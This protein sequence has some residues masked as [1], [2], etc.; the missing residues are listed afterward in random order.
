M[1]RESSP[2]A[3]QSVYCRYHQPW[4]V[5]TKEREEKKKLLKPKKRENR[6]T[7]VSIMDA[8]VNGKVLCVRE[9]KKETYHTSLMENTILQMEMEEWE[10]FITLDCI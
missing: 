6:N 3:S 7:S 9:R 10:K 4:L 5:R 1:T 2:R 8:P